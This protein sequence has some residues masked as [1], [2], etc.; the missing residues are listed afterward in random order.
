MNI[1]EKKDSVKLVLRARA[2]EKIIYLRNTITP[3]VLTM[4]TFRIGP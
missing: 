2:T 1:D 4:V 3:K